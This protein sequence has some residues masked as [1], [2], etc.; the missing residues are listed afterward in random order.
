MIAFLCLTFYKETQVYLGKKNKNLKDRAIM[1]LDQIN[2]NYLR[3]FESVYRTRS[4]TQAALELH[5]TQSG[6][7]QH[8]RSLED[9]LETKLF[10]RIKQKLIP[11]ASGKQLYEDVSPQLKNLELALNSVSTKDQ[12]LR[13]EVTIGLP[14]VFGL[15]LVIPLLKEFGSLHPSI[16]FNLRF[17]LGQ[18]LNSML[19]NGEVDFAFVDDFNMDSQIKTEKVYDEVLKLYCS[20]EYYKS[21]KKDLLQVKG[22]SMYEI[23]E[24]IAYQKGEPILRHW[25]KQHIKGGMIQLNVRAYVADALGISRFITSGMGA[26]ILPGHHGDKLVEQGY[27]LYE[28]DSNGKETINKISVAF[29][30]NRTHSSAVQKTLEFLKERFQ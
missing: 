18:N 30:H 12:R 6:I 15:N 17:E 11:T 5:L 16:T 21:K 10:D 23:F 2:L 14:V 7:S 19:L 8:I 24:Y 27:K 22:K 9:S 13:G 29:V 26:G 20:E 28:F 25:F 4:M 3:I 1:L